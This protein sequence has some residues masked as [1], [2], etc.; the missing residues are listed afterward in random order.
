MK[1]GTLIGVLT[2]IMTLLAG[3]SIVTA[4]PTAYTVK[5]GDCLWSVASA[6]GTTVDQIKQLNGLSSELLQVGQVLKLSADSAPIVQAPSVP[7][8]QP[9]SSAL[10]TAPAA[11]STTPAP[12]AASAN[13]SSYIVQPGD[14]LWTI[15]SAQ[16]MTV[17]EIRQLNGLSA[18]LLTVGQVLELTTSPNQPAAAETPAPAAPAADPA[19]ASLYVIQPGDTLWTIAQ[20]YGTSVDNI[21]TLNG[22]TG[23]ALFAGESLKVTGTPTAVSVSRSGSSATGSRVIAK[24]AQYLGTPYR[25]GGASPGGFDCSG[26]TSYVFQ[27]FGISLNRSAA[28]QYGQGSA[29]S[30]ASLIAGDLV[31]FNTYGGVSHVGIYTGNGEFIHSSSPQSGGV[32]YS[33]LSESYYASRYVG[34]R[35]VIR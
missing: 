9:T 35:R 26:F 33:A 11:Q 13:T 32:I 3:S 8:A 22:L 20:L 12:A 18:D 16:G 10:E 15:A 23:D 1:K 6:H 24:A 2:L 21:R 25:Y 29:V 4:A 17:N 27:Q 34:A 14:N 28:G 31:F 30:K 7:A 19:G 5:S